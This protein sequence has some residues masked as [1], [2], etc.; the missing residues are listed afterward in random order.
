MMRLFKIIIHITKFIKMGNK[1]KNLN[2]NNLFD[3]MNQYQGVNLTSGL[4]NNI[5]TSQQTVIRR[6]NR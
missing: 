5:Y 4:E 2:N 6:L 1:F 3:E